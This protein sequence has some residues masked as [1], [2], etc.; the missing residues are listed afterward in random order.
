MHESGYFSLP[1]QWMR[2]TNRFAIVAG[3]VMGL[4]LAFEGISASGTFQVSPAKKQVPPAIA[5]L[6]DKLQQLVNDLEGLVMEYKALLQDEPHPYG[7]GGGEDPNIK[8]KYQQ[9]L[10]VWED[11]VEQISGKIVEKQKKI[12]EVQ[13]QLRNLMSQGL[14]AARNKDEENSR[15]AMEEAQRKLEGRANFLHKRVVEFNARVSNR[16]PV[17][18]FGAIRAK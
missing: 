9:E 3:I 6:M 7:T 14:P 1:E 18:P 4:I 12:Q 2:R 17:R 16:H 10:H 13:S 15:K 5:Q 8:A 11:K